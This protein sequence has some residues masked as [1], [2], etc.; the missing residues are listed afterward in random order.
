ML[1]MVQLCIH[2]HI[3][4]IAIELWLEP[5]E[6]FADMLPATLLDIESDINFLFQKTEDLVQSYQICSSCL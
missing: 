4:E 6:V 2:N 3:C 5:I 1:D